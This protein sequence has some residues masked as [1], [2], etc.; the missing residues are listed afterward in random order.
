MRLFC[1]PRGERTG[2][3]G[4]ESQLPERPHD[5]GGERGDPRTAADHLRRGRV[6]LRQRDRHEEGSQRNRE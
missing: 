4:R 2:G 5:G 3:G 6:E 1:F